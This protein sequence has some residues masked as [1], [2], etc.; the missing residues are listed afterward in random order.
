QSQNLKNRFTKIQIFNYET[1]GSKI[2]PN[3]FRAINGVV[4]V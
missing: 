4:F 3:Q 2:L 1:L